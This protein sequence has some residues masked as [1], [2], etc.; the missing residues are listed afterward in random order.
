MQDETKQK[1]REKF[2]SAAFDNFAELEAWTTQGE[3]MTYEQVMLLLEIIVGEE[4]GGKE[5]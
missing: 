3:K 2:N 4:S 5:E 1:I